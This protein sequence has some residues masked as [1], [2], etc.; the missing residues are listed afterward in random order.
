VTFCRTLL[1][2]AAL[3]CSACGDDTVAST[4]LAASFDLSASPDDLATHDLA[5]P[6]DLVRDWS[7]SYADGSGLCEGGGVDAGNNVAGTCVQTF[8]AKL[9]DCWVPSGMC[10]ANFSS[11][12]SWD[13]CWQSGAG[14]RDT[15]CE[16]GGLATTTASLYVRGEAVCMRRASHG[17]AFCQPQPID[18]WTAPDGTTLSIVVAT[19]DVTCPDG[20]H[21]TIGPNYGNCAELE[22]LLRPEGDGHCPFGNAA[23]DCPPALP[24]F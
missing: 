21:V 24:S 10:R 19:G 3:A 13:A 9:A 6:Y 22:Q 17:G 8:F 20:S 5:G 11:H 7:F 12:T 2:A 16:L 4:D 18:D 15:F 23:V 14:R 1:L